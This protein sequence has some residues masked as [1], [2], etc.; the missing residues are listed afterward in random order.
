MPRGRR[1]STPRRS[2]RGTL[3][4]SLLAGLREFGRAIAV[5][6]DAA[7]L[8]GHRSLAE[9]IA[10]FE[11]A[12]ERAGRA[13][14]PSPRPSP[15]PAPR[16][17]AATT[18]RRSPPPRGPPDRAGPPEG[19]RDGDRRPPRP[20]PARRG[21]GSLAPPIVA[22]HPSTR[23]GGS[24][25]SGPSGPTRP[26]P[27]RPGPPPTPRFSGSARPGRL[28]PRGRPSPSCLPPSPRGGRRSRREFL[29]DHWQKLILGLAVLLIV[30]SSTVGA[31]L[32]LGDRLWRPRGNAC[33]RRPIP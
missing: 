2:G 30:V 24:S 32:V 3:S 10:E 5:C 20:W 17:P 21:G 28:R 22:S 31:A 25:G 9:R 8:H 16:R 6:R 15:G 27:T 4:A 14:R 19:A 1:P 29:E 23:P 7:E 13:P 11:A 12:A 26:S 33:W 18:R